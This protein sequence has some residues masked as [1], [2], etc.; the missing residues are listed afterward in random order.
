METQNLF[1]IYFG[2]NIG[3][4]GRVND[5]KIEVFIRDIIAPVFDGFTVYDAIGYWKDKPEDC[6]IV[7]IVSDSK[8]AITCSIR[9]ICNEYKRQFNQES[10]LITRQPVDTEFV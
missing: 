8:I 10:V 2:R 5:Y 7:E 3:D 6:F 4:Y 9:L 1:R